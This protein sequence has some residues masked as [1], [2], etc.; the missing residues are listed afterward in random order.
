MEYA[1]GGCMCKELKK[2]GGMF[3]EK[4]AQFYAAEITLALE[5]LHRYGIVHR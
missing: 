4:R 2:A 5:F 1:S 3:I